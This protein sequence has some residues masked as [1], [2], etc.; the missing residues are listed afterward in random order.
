[1]RPTIPALTLAAT[2]AALSA[3]PP[4]AAQQFPPAPPPPGP[5]KPAQF[6]P[7][8][9][10]TLTNG[11]H[12]ILVENHRLPVLSVSLSF[13]GGSRYDAPGKEGTADAV[14]LLLT[15]GAGKRD[16]DAVAAAIE[17]VGGALSASAGRDFLT[18]NAN[19][20]SLDAPLVFELMGDALIRP[21]FIAKE[22]ELARTQALSGLQL[23]QSQPAS[24]AERF[25]G[26]GLYGAHPYGRHPDAASV[27][28]VTRDDLVAFQKARLRPG[29]ALLVLAGD[30]TLAKAKL[31]AESAF[32]GWTGTSLAAATPSEPP[33]RAA[34][35]ILLVHRPGSVQSN[36][37]VGNLTWA[38]TDPRVYAANL[39]NKV[40]GG[41]GD[42]RLFTILREQKGWTYGAY[43]RLTRYKGVGFFE[44]SAEVRTEVT[45]SSLVEMLAQVRRIRSEPVPQ[46]E[47]DDSKSALVGRFPLQV[48]TAEQVA[49]Q[50]STARLLGLPNDYVQTYRQRLAA[51]TP[52]AAQA[53]ATAAMR[54]DQALVVV[55]GD[56]AKIYEKLAKIAPVNIISPDGK[57]LTAGD[58]SV[59]AAALDLRMERFMAR[60]DSFAIF[61][62]GNPLGYQT[63]KLEAAEGGWRYTETT[64]IAAFVQQDLDVRFTDKL[65]MQSVK[66]TGKQ[67]GQDANVDV[68]FSNGHA[69]G[70]ATTPGQAGPK[71]VNV[72]TDIPAGTIDANL[73]T[74]IVPALKWAAGATFTLP[75]FATDKGIVVPYTI[76]VSGEESVKVPLGTFDVYKAEVT[77]GEQ[78][79]TIWV[80]K[81]APNRVIKIGFAGAPIEMQR[82]R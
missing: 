53:A 69:K 17:G 26:R 11:V 15:K 55:V 14:A 56:G 2:L 16:A 34:T 75:V 5:I 41:G 74:V 64:R 80:E 77:G 44:A 30:I 50:V 81:A 71:T 22:V 57:T 60:S 66:E 36:I 35:E 3:L 61:L 54:P 6:P 46:K 68:T 62:Q 63:S 49:A 18:V 32:S 59:K 47:F 48:E 21:A 58:L 27:K 70:T 29:G 9:E 76:A 10:A 23:E 82:V 12:L 4:L 39:V 28:A 67:A 20:L 13:A 7:F 25:L 38:P 37:L 19:A 79:L 8:Q 65:V 42:S 1:M 51:V 43:S 40:L 33:A 31:L 45:D 78:P 24:I 52:A 72:D 73:V